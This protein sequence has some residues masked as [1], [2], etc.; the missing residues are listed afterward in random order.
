MNDQMNQ[1][2][3]IGANLYKQGMLDYESMC[4]AY[5]CD[6]D[7]TTDEQMAFQ[8][9]VLDKAQIS[10]E[11]FSLGKGDVVYCKDC[12]K[13]MVCQMTIGKPKDWYCA[14]GVRLGK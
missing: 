14:D 5:L 2:I 9:R 11:Q 13:N 3:R 6:S 1:F 8:D 4:E 12:R 7:F 10:F